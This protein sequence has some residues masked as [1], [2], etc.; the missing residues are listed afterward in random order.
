MKTP[1]NGSPNGLGMRAENELTW[2][3]KA[4]LDTSTSNSPSNSCPPF[5]GCKTCLASRISPAHVP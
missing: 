2:D 5:L 4:F 1:G 3:P